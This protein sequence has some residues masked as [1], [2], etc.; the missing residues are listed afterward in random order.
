MSLPNV[1]ADGATS[2]DVGVCGTASRLPAVDSYMMYSAHKSVSGEN[3]HRAAEL[4]DENQSE[5]WEEIFI[6]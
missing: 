3:F 4:R 5:G 2:A 1:L 6:Q